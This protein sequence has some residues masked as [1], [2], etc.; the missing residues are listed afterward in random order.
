M[1]FNMEKFSVKQISDF[2]SKYFSNNKV[3]T[4]DVKSKIYICTTASQL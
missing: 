1:G 2:I 3:C 4:K